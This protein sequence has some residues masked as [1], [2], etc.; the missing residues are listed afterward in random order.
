MPLESHADWV[1]VHRR[2]VVVTDD[3]LAKV[4]RYAMVPALLGITASRT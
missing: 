4:E 1:A 3:Q 2:M